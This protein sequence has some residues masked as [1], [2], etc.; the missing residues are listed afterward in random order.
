MLYCIYELNT[1][2]PKNG[3]STLYSIYNVAMETSAVDDD[4]T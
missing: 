2:F 1:L 3:L 4:G